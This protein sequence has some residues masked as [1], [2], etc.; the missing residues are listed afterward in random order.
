MQI[1]W[2][3]IALEDIDEIAEYIKKDNPAAAQ[4]VVEIIYNSV[5]VLS[6]NPQIGRSGRVAG[7]RELILREVPFIVPYRIHEEAIEILRV[8][9]A[10]REWPDDFS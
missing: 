4:R 7:T 8:L 1:K 10:A 6:V 5:N 9:H 2:L 3:R